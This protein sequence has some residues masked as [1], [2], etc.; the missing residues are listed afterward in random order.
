METGLS[1]EGV[2]GAGTASDQ[3]CSHF[4]TPDRGG[5]APPTSLGMRRLGSYRSSTSDSCGQK[6][7]MITEIMRKK[8]QGRVA[9][10]SEVI[11]RSKR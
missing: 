5:D 2:F 7:M 11:E 8:N 10:Y 1:P 3:G 6:A 9:V 4:P